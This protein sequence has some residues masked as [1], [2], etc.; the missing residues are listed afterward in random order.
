[1]RTK[2]Q[3]LKYVPKN[4][5]AAIKDAWEDSDG[6]W[7]ILKAGWNADRMDFNCHTIHEET[8]SELRYQIA[9]IKKKTQMPVW[10]YDEMMEDQGAKKVWIVYHGSS[11]FNGQIYSKVFLDEDAAAAKQYYEEC[12]PTAYRELCHTWDIWNYTER[13][14]KSVS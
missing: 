11:A 9:G 1:M 4:K 5:Q 6:M 7:I 8:V 13:M 10:E 12:D 14:K 2:D 3:I